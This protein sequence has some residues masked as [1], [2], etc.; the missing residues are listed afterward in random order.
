MRDSKQIWDYIYGSSDADYSLFNL[1]TT[2]IYNSHVNRSV[3]N[4]TPHY[5]EHDKPI[6][7]TLQEERS[8]PFINH[9]D[10]GFMAVRAHVEGEEMFT[11]YGEHW[12]PERGLALPNQPLPSPAEQLEFLI[13]GPFHRI[14]MSDVLVQMSALAPIYVHLNQNRR[15]SRVRESISLPLPPNEEVKI[16]IGRGLFANRDFSEGDLITVMPVVVLKKEW[17][18]E[19]SRRSP[20]LIQNYCLWDGQAD[21]V[22]LP[23]STAIM[24]NHA[25]FLSAAVS[26]SVSVSQRRAIPQANTDMRWFSWRKEDSWQDAH[27][28]V[29]AHMK[30]TTALIESHIAPLDLAIYATRNISHGEELYMDYGIEWEERWRQALI[31]CAND[32]T[33]HRL[34]DGSDVCVSIGKFR[35]Y[36][37]VTPGLFP[38]EWK[39]RRT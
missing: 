19:V 28:Q 12:Y 30:F 11:F 5:E 2:M 10:S 8:F 23:V 7:R 17:V 32:I 33:F 35:S 9:T 1:G 21:I 4:I 15:P 20:S 26:P 24:M 14:C 22:L 34:S 27:D 3:T 38:N 18:D 39:N 6:A 31:R 16:E 37:Y 25:P 13:S 36:V 29:F